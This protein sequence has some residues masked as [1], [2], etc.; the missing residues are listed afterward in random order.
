M[1]L[2]A[3]FGEEY[4]ITDHTQDQHHFLLRFYRS[5]E[6]V[7]EEAAISRLYSGTHYRA[8]IEAG[9]VQGRCIG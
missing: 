7:A 2:T 4:A 5:L 8:A 1:V 9:L 6:A 3:L